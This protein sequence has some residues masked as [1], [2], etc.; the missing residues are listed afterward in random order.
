[1]LT[2]KLLKSLPTKEMI[3][4]EVTGKLIPIEDCEVIVIKIIKDKN[5]DLSN[6]NPFNVPSSN[7]LGPIRRDDPQMIREQPIVTKDK[8]IEI[9]P[10]MVK[11]YKKSII[12]PAFAS[13]MI[14]PDMPGAATESRH[15]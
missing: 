14:P 13:T 8:E 11:R 15:I 4:C 7:P 2:D 6:Y 10:E 1:M 9:T 3:R 12:P 5:A